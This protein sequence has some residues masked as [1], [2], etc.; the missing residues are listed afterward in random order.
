MQIIL[1]QAATAFKLS[2]QVT[3][4]RFKV[5]AECS[6]NR[7]FMSSRLNVMWKILHSRWTVVLRLEWSVL[8]W[9]LFW[10]FGPWRLDKY[11]KW[12]LLFFS[13]DWTMP[14]GLNF[15]M[16]VF[17]ST[18]SPVA[19]QTQFFIPLFKSRY[20]FIHTRNRPNSEPLICST[21]EKYSVFEFTKVK[22]CRERIQVRSLF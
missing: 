5:Q 21:I 9:T 22:K 15:R 14:R 2:I 10:N 18:T 3:S 13:L 1:L 12:T 8:Q 16:H 11:D 6:R 7:A 20:S 4:A 17:G 19:K